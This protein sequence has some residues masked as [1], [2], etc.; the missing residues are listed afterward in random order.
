MCDSGSGSGFISCMQYLVGSSGIIISR[1]GSINS[2]FGSCVA[3]HS[4]S[5]SLPVASLHYSSFL[6]IYNQ[7]SCFPECQCTG[8]PCL[9]EALNR[10]IMS[11]V[12]R[13]SGGADEG[14]IQLAVGYVVCRR[15][16]SS[17]CVAGVNYSSLLCRWNCQR[18]YQSYFL[19]PFDNNL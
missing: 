8:H 5:Q 11:I 10:S 1:G 18:F 3:Q 12:Q 9:A 14:Q 13:R 17:T 7:C 15:Y 6:S 2:G 19:L 4:I 16:S